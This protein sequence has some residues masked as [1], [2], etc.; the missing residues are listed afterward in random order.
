MFGMG[1]ER[2]ITCTC[3]GIVPGTVYISTQV[4]LLVLR[5]YL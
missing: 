1:E 2:F 4:V 5:V 3:R